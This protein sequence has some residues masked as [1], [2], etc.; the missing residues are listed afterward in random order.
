[1]KPLALWK[2]VLSD[3][4]VS[5]SHG[6]FMTWIKPT[7][8]TRVQKLDVG[9][10][11][12]EIS[13][14]SAYHKQY[15][16]ERYQGQLKEVLDRI[17]RQNNNLT[18]AVSDPPSSELTLETNNGPLFQVNQTSKS[19]QY[20]EAVLQ[21]RLREDFTFQTF[22]VSSSNEMAHAA[23]QAIAKSP[24]KSLQSF[25]YLRWGGCGKN[26]SYPSDCK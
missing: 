17:T 2:T 16:E 1:M 22:A 23:A 9:S 21:V 13:C 10:Q 8:I 11:L 20:R 14:P 24:G 18:F 12:V 3:L 26:S 7:K 4:E 6:N 5:V 15:L 19:S 25:F